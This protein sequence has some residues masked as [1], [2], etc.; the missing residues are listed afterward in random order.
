MS[1]STF[2]GNTAAKDGGA[3][4]NGDEG[5][6]GHLTVTGSTFTSNTSASDG[7]AINSNDTGATTGTLTVRDPAS[8]PTSP[9]PTAGP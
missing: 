5:G 2:T 1:T 6:D 3:I 4:D 8:M 9:A 7:G